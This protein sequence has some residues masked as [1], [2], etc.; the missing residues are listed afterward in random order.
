M[1]HSQQGSNNH[2]MA[3]ATERTASSEAE[4]TTVPTPSKTSNELHDARSHGFEAQDEKQDEGDYPS[5]F[6]LIIMIVALILSMFLASLDMTIIGTAIPVITDEFH[7]LDQVGWYGSVFFLTVAAF[8]ASWGKAY[9]FFDMK[10]VFLS[11]IFLFEVGSLLCGVAPNSNTLVAGRAVTGV[12]AAG[13]MGGAYSIVA[14]AVPPH[15][16]P[17]LTALMGATFGIASVVGPLLGGVFTDQVSWRW[18][19][20][21]NLPVGG[22]SAAMILFLFRTPDASRYKGDLAFTQ[23]LIHMDFPGALLILAA[24][25]CYLLAMQWG[26]TTKAWNDSEVYGTLIGFGLIAIAFG[27]VEWKMGERGL[28]VPYL[29]RQRVTWAG[30]VFLSFIG[31]G[32]FTLLYYLPIYFQAV[33]GTSAEQS[34]IRFLALIGAQTVFTIIAGAFMSS[35]GLFAPLMI[36]GAIISTIAAGLI[37]MLDPSSGA[38]EWA[39][40][41]VVAGIGNGLCFQVPIMAG[42][43]LAKDE[44]VPTTTALL[45]WF[46]TIGGSLGLSAAQAAFSNE[47]LNSLRR[48]APNTSPSQVLLVGATEIRKAFGP[49]EI[50]GIINAYMDGLRVAFIFVIALF[51]C[52]TVISIATPWTNI[53]GKG[54]GM[55]M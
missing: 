48:H 35:V 22:A 26:G 32:F 6:R 49:D 23:K 52:A 13:V 27:I 51:G 15:K 47:L 12:G 37:Y 4:L 39:G 30:C 7:S 24:V 28:L 34:G 45:M 38:G 8:Q 14:Y 19:F 55:A 1:D 54:K 44:D 21:I 53:K 36:L 18:C 2:T 46:Q 9:K 43:A 5:T 11:S 42:Q 29:L 16:R 40:Y 10:Y 17:L 20:Y 41:Q 33:L 3:T 31:A 50:P 25:I